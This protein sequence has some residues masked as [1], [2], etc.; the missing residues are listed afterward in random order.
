MAMISQKSWPT[1]EKKSCAKISIRMSHN[2]G[3]IKRQF[4]GDRAA[5]AMK[6]SAT[7]QERPSRDAICVVRSCEIVGIVAHDTFHDFLP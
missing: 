5:I 4:P 7:N 6:F 2:R 3:S 1:K